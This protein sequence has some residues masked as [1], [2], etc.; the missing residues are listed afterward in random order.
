MENEFIYIDHAATTPVHPDVLQAMQPYF[1]EMY[2]NP[3]SIH[4]FGQKARQAIDASR[5]RIAGLL[6]CTV[7]EL[8]FTSGG[9]ESNNLAIRGTVTDSLGK[10]VITS[11]VE[12]HAVLHVCRELERLGCEVTYL[13]VDE[14]GMVKPEDVRAA[15]R[16]QTAL[17]SIMYGNNEVGTLQP[18][19][20]IGTLAREHGI[21]FHVDAVQAPGNAELLLSRLPVDLMSLSAHKI[22]GPKGIGALYV[23]R[24][25]QLQSQLFGGSQERKR[26]AGTENVA[27]IVGFATAMELACEQTTRKHTWLASLRKLLID[28]LIE[29]MGSDSFVVNGHPQHHLPHIVNISFPGIRAETMLMNLD[30]EGIA[31][32]SGSA[33]SAGSL[34]PSHVLRAMSLPESVQ[35]SAVRFSMAYDTTEKEILKIVKKIETI[36]HRLRIK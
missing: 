10:H 5:T 2:G 14:Q 30:L 12:H 19:E 3:S 6:S 35:A 36:Y 31:A 22:R 1:I 32:S 33:C 9:T 15:I 20:E 18:I 27:S 34:E 26:R 24:G 4:R 13:P 11:T 29:S 8:V 28:R 7:D 23:R 17:I 16:E 25:T 21:L